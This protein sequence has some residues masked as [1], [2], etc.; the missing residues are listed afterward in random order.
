MAKRTLPP[1]AFRGAALGGSRGCPA[2]SCWL[3]RLPTA[4]PLNE[5][6]R[7]SL[8]GNGG[9]DWAPST[10]QRRGLIWSV[11]LARWKAVADISA[12]RVCG[13]DSAAIAPFAASDARTARIAPSD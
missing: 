9:Y 2:L 3:C 4:A 5:T 11:S 6:T 1:D 7:V 12:S 13:A 8:Q 10:R